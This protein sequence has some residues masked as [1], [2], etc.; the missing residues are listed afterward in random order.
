MQA[1][2][3]QSQPLRID[4]HETFRFVNAQYLVGLNSIG[5]IY[6]KCATEI[7]GSV[8]EAV[9][10]GRTAGLLALGYNFLALTGSHNPM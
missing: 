6:F 5:A 8:E 1:L 10:K 9:G 7:Q 2:S 4:I 3:Y